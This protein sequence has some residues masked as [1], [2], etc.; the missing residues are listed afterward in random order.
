[1]A[2]Q[3]GPGQ[4]VA[5]PASGNPAGLLRHRDLVETGLRPTNVGLRLISDSDVVLASAVAAEPLEPIPWWY[6]KIGT[7]LWETQDRKIAR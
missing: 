3:V 2:R 1:M 7:H 6:P 4:P 5:I